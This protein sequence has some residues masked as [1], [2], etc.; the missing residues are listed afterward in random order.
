MRCLLLLPVLFLLAG[1]GEAPRVRIKIELAGQAPEEPKPVATVPGLPKDPP[2]PNSALLDS[3]VWLRAN[4]PVQWTC[5]AGWEEIQSTRPQRLVEFTVKKDGPGGAPV[6]FLVLNGADDHPAARQAS[7]T[8]WETFFHADRPTETTTNEHD[9][10]KVVKMKVH[11]TFEGQP[12]L[13]SSET[14][15]EP[16]WT[17]ICGWVEGPDGSILFKFQGPDDIVQPNEAKADQLLA[18][19]KPRGKKQ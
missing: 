18:S 4:A 14:V 3:P 17:M 16:N 8:R 7:I 15:N 5:P 9:G 19:M 2:P 12:V 11:G 1:C 6:Q 13:G 10:V